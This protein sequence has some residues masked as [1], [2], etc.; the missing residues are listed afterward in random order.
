MKKLLLLSFVVSM[1]ICAGAQPVHSLGKPSKANANVEIITEQPEG[2]VVAYTRSGEYMTAS[3]YGYESAQQ[4]GQMKITYADDNKTVY[5]LD[6]LAYGEGT[7]VWVQGE[8]SDDGTTITVPLGQYVAYNEDYGY[9]LILAWGQNSLIDL[10]D[11]FYWMDFIPDEGVEAVTYSVDPDNGVVT[12][13]G[14]EGDASATY[15]DNLL[16]HGL[17]GI[18]S[19]D[20]SLATIE[21]GTTFTPLSDAVAAVPA[22]PEA[23]EF[24]DCGDESGY[25][26]FDFNIN[27]TD[28][29]GN[30]LHADLVTYSIYIDQD[31]LFTFDAATYGAANGF[32]EDMTEIPYGFSGADFYL[33]R[34]Y[35]YR[36][37]S[38]DNP[39]LTW[40]IGIQTHYT[41]DG[42][43]NSSNIVYLEVFPQSGIETVQ[44]GKTVV[45]ERYYNVAGQ[46][47]TNPKGI[48]I[49]V[50]SYS[51]GTTSTTKVIK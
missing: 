39:L 9:G 19:D 49:K 50:T 35:F 46:E 10:G 1:A 15:P 42:V 5:L 41:V 22:D 48:A 40:R 8:L 51:D 11:D 16:A 31:E 44:P 32:D 43:R 25:T 14:S 30:E 28:V 27:L 18:W 20:N 23:L 33:R 45:A 4:T 34:V 12:L 21:W 37:N 7:G 13:L 24:F 26:R 6:P 2:N 29:D 3:L 36:T 38:G 47:V 17:A